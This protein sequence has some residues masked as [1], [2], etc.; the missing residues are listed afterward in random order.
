LGAFVLG[1]AIGLTGDEAVKLLEDLLVHDGR[2]GAIT[3]G[4]PI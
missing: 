2:S 4:R 1:F 3:P